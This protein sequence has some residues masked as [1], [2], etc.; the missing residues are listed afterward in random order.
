[1]TPQSR[2]LPVLLTRPEAA[3]DRFAAELAAAFGDRVAVL[4]SPLLQPLLLRPALPDAAALVLTSETGV[5]AAAGYGAGLP[6]RAYCVGRRTADAASAAGFQAISADGDA[7]A[8]VALILR[9][10]E[11]GPLL[12]LHGRDT[13]G[14]VVPRLAAAGLPATGAVVYAQDPCPLTPAARALLDG[15][16]PVVVPL[17]SPR[18]AQLF[19]ATAPHRA[20]LWVAALSPA[21]AAALGSLPVA[22]LAVADAPDA[23]SLIAALGP[24]IG[25]GNA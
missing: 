14:D 8:L 13:R 17:F 12:H 16:G 5:R 9:S 25:A 3:G 15:A 7:D 24:L 19:A 23:G 20:A 21:V 1:M 22:R 4:S 18:T 11:R 10:G 6:R 2:A